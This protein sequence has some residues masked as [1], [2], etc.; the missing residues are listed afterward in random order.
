MSLTDFEDDPHELT[1]L[2]KVD[3]LQLALISRATGDESPE[4]FDYS[5]TRRELLK[6]SDVNERLPSYVKRHRDLES[7]WPFIKAKFGTYAERRGSS[8]ETALRLLSIT[9]NYGIVPRPMH[10][11]RIL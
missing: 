3:L 1:L 10:L 9:S 4:G 11:L 7:F 8:S 5:D 2:D 6:I